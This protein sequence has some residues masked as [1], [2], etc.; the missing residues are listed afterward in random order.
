M[1]YGKKDKSGI[2]IERECY[3]EQFAEPGDI[4]FNYLVMDWNQCIDEGKDPQELAKRIEL[5]ANRLN[6]IAR[7]LRKKKI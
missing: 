7:F 6:Q 1:I 4:K 2:K 5:K 3:A